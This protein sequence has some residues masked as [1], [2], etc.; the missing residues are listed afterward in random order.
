MSNKLHSANYK[1]FRCHRPGSLHVDVL[2]LPADTCPCVRMS[3]YLYP[4]PPDVG[5][6][7][8]CPCV[9]SWVR[10][11]VFH[12]TTVA[13]GRSGSWRTNVRNLKL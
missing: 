7:V 4:Y 6:C 3:V 9:L 5:G 11:S 8:Q 10:A 1:D 12:S 2:G 13:A